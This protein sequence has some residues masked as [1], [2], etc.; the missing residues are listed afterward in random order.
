MLLRNCKTEEY[1][2]KSD[3][4]TSIKRKKLKEVYIANMVTIDKII[5]I[6]L[7]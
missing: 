6:I 2:I 5:A 3:K 7:G 1:V 4:Y